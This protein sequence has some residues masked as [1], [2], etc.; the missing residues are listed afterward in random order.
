[1]CVNE[2]IGFVNVNVNDIIIIIVD[3]F[4]SFISFFRG[5]NLIIVIVCGII[6]RIF[7]NDAKI[8]FSLLTFLFLKY[9]NCLFFILLTINFMIL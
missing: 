4:V 1:M 2:L 5:V 8:T 3:W 7:G 9:R 6:I